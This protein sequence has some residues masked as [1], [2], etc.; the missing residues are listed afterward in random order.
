MKNMI[1]KGVG[2]LFAYVKNAQGLIVPKLL[3]ARFNTLKMDFKVDLESIY[4]GDG[5]FRIDSFVKNKEIDISLENA[6]FD[7]NQLAILLGA[8]VTIAD[9]GAEV[10]VMSEAV[11]PTAASTPLTTTEVDLVF[12]TTFVA[13]SLAARYRDG[14]GNLEVVATKAEV[15][16]AGKIYVDGNGAVSYYTAAGAGDNG[17]EISLYYKR[18]VT[19]DTAPI[20]INDEPMV[21]GVIQQA[22]Y[23]QKDNTIQGVEIEIYAAQPYG[24]F[25]FENKRRTASTHSL[26]LAV[27]DAD[28]A[29]GCL[30][31]IKRYLAS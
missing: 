26:Q 22:K 2:E 6:E 18:T 14:S 13:G 15:N 7:L 5:L 20:M 25:S 9:T 19:A 3:G 24:T 12:K 11:K 8:D 4:G 28:R 1:I 23:R 17:K 31:T 27:Q 29:D 21:L 16:A 30:G 10:F